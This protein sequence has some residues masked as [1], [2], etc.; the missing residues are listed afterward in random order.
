[1]IPAAI[2][3]CPRSRSMAHT[4]PSARIRR[5]VLNAVEWPDLMRKAL[6]GERAIQVDVSIVNSPL[7]W[8]T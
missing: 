6:P 7:F 4:S 5:A 3:A 8:E 2:I 1:M